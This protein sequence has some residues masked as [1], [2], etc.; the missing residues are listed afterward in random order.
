MYGGGES[1]R[2]GKLVKQDIHPGMED[3][4][5][6]TGS[7]YRITFGSYLV[8]KNDSR[9]VGMTW[10]NIINETNGYSENND[11]ITIGEAIF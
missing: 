6:D 5:T 2:E 3:I 8:Y 4:V 7:I 1:V 9:N 11:K 10:I